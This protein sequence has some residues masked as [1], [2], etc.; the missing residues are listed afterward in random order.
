M[1][2]AKLEARTSFDK[3]LMYREWVSQQGGV[4]VKKQADSDTTFTPGG[5]DSESEYQLISPEKLARMVYE[6]ADKSYEVRNHITSLQP[7]Y[8]GNAPDDWE[9]QALHRLEAGDSEAFDIQRVGNRK[10][11]RFMGK[12]V[13]EPSCLP[14][15][16]TQ[17]FKVG[18]V[19]GGIS[20]TIPFEPYDKIYHGHAKLVLAAIGIIWLAG[21][22]VVIIMFRAIRNEIAINSDLITDLKKEKQYF[23][24]L[25]QNSPEGI[26]LVDTTSKILRVNNHFC[27]VFGYE[28]DEIIGKNV[29]LLIADQKHRREALSITELFSKHQKE[30][31]FESIR[32]HKDGHPIEVSILGAPVTDDK[33]NRHILGI[34]RDIS[35][36]KQIER[37]LKN[38]EN[39]YK[40]LSNRLAETN[41]L[42]DLLLDIITHDLKNPAGL[43]SGVVGVLKDDYPENELVD[44]IDQSAGNI[45]RVI[46]NASAL[47][48]LSMDETIETRKLDLVPTICQIVNNFNQFAREAGMTIET[49][50][51]SE[52]IVNAHIIIEEVFKN[53]IS[54]SLKYAT[55]GKKIMITSNADPKSVTVNVCDYGDTIPAE[56]R[57]KIFTRSFQL[58][59]AE[60]RGS[61]LGLSIVSKIATAHHAAVG[62][63]PNTPKGNIFFITFPVTPA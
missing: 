28:K 26:V 49:D 32:T 36:R 10:I 63:V 41:S 34:Y 15:H 55:D 14:C 7:M 57:K 40:K 39:K 50:L 24:N 46:D 42:K 52:L 21:I 13:T 9:K 18:D 12:L 60:G 45:L 54:N 19:R 61:G 43:I 22:V 2:M 47:S 25:F 20:I 17:G 30:K 59:N 1:R 8:M 37:D 62:V 31:M 5:I 35:Q 4:Y 33:G 38:S 48:K 29:D 23:E 51:P 44:I 53:Y 27:T 6:I 56:F 58:N 11:F 16:G 3:D